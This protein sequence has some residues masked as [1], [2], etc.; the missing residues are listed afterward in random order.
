MFEWLDI[1]LYV[2]RQTRKYK[3]YVFHQYFIQV[4]GTKSVNANKLAMN[5]MSNE[6]IVA[7]LYSLVNYHLG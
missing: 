1:G 6:I 5:T 4:T 7:L 3:Y 2:C